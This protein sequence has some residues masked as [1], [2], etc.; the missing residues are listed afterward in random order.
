MVPGFIAGTN[1]I[2]Y[3]NP[4]A[5]GPD[6]SLFT[7]LADAG[8]LIPIPEPGTAP[9]VALGLCGLAANARQRARASRSAPA[10]S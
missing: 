6:G 3:E 8:L 7:I 5:A 10:H 4:D 2:R 1:T 9:L